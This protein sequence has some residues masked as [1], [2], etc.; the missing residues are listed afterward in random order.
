MSEVDR[1]IQVGEQAFPEI[2]YKGILDDNI[3]NQ[4]EALK[5]Y[6]IVLVHLEAPDEAGHSG[7]AEIKK[8]A[9]LQKEMC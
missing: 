1:I 7:S 2:D 8:K 9:V 4:I 3:E 5:E 6:D